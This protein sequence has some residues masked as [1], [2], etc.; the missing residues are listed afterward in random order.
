MLTKGN[1]GMLILSVVAVFA[2]LRAKMGKD[3]EVLDATKPFA[4]LLMIG[5]CSWLLIVLCFFVPIIIHHWPQAALFSIALGGAVLA[6]SLPARAH[7]C[8]D[9][10]CGSHDDCLGNQSIGIFCLS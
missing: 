4:Y 5:I 2:M 9:R 3:R 7:G 10:R 6:G 8:D 1:A